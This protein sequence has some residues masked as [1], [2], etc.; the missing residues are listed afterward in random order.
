MKKTVS[1]LFLLTAVLV[2]VPAQ[3]TTVQVAPSDQ[4]IYPDASQILNKTEPKVEPKVEPKPVPA[5]A[6][7]EPLTATP[8]APE[9]APA[10]LPSA[11]P[12]VA[13]VPVPAR[14]EP[15]VAPAPAKALPAA[16]KVPAGPQW[17]LR[18]TV[19]GNEEGVRAWAAALG[20]EVALNPLGTDLWEVLQGPLNEANLK[21]A[22]DGQAGKAQ[23][24]RR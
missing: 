4:V 15:T 14:A 20:P 12:L 8:A 10:P 9:K 7:S 3:E 16:P 6:K 18:W 19:T 21:K 1:C 5:P 17:F 2:W 13:A 11:K 23:L 22:L 24:I